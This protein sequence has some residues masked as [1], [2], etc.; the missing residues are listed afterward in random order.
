MICFLEKNPTLRI[1]EL[2]NL[3]A[4]A[5]GESQGNASVCMIASADFSVMVPGE[6]LYLLAHGG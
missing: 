5:K 4:N 3:M 6:K 2:Y 1:F